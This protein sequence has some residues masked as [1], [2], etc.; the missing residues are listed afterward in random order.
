MDDCSDASTALIEFPLGIDSRPRLFQRI[1]FPDV[2][3]A[4][5]RHVVL[6][7]VLR[8]VPGMIVPSLLQ[9]CSPVAIP[10]I[11]D[12]DVD[13][14]G[15]LQHLAN[16]GAPISIRRFEE[17]GMPGRE[18]VERLLRGF[19]QKAQNVDDE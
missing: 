12:G 1:A 16:A 7:K 19:R 3:A 10:E 4:S 9:R 5:L 8:I 13:R 14:L 18:L 11:E 15:E 2:Y 6:V 17:R